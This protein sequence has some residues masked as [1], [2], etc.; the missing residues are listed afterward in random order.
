MRPYNACP[1]PID[2][3]HSAHDLEECTFASRYYQN[4]SKRINERL[5]QYT[6]CPLVITL[7]LTK[8]HLFFL[9]LSVYKSIFFEY[10][11]FFLNG[12]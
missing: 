3:F 4:S 12:L 11:F 2:L 8:T 7:R 6:C 1:S 10:G 5:T 9:P